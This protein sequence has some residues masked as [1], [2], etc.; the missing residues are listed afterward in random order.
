MTTSLHPQ[1]PTTPDT[2][3]GPHGRSSDTH[4]PG[5]RVG[6][7]DWPVIRRLSAVS[8]ILGGAL[9]V[10]GGTLHP[11]VDGKGHSVEA[12]Q[13]A[14]APWAQI[15]LA[16]GT[17]LVLLGMPGMYV[18]LR[19]RIGIAGFVGI[20]LYFVGNVVTSTAH[21]AVE[22]FVAYPFA[23]DPTTA[24][25]IA[26]DDSM[27]GTPE[28]IGIN[29]F[30]AV[31]MLVGLALLGSSLIRNRAVPIWIGVLITI[32]MVGFLLPLPAVAGISGFFWEAPRGI[33]V[34]AIGVLML[35]AA[36]AA[37]ADRT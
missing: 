21:L 20:V 6:R 17:I 9:C 11:I 23:N 4:A 36:S 25:L 27:L 33:G 7:P 19:P 26:D 2:V 8:L 16:V 29:A 30:G 35:R 18:W 31:V 24:H 13:G 15:L 3:S 10:A 32:G 34:A 5:L 12:L 14:T 22:I 1:H 37:R 28:F